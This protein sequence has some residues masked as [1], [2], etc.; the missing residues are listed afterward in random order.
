[1]LKFVAE[2]VAHYEWDAH[3]L[4]KMHGSNLA[5]WTASMTDVLNKGDELAIY[6]MCDMLKRHAFVYTRTKPWTTVDSNVGKLDVTELCMLCDVCLIYLGNKRFGELKCKPEIL[7]PRPRLLPVKLES[8]K[9]QKNSEQTALSPTKELVVGVLDASQSSCTLMTLPCSPTTSILESSKNLLAMKPDVE[10]NVETCELPVVETLCV[11]TSGLET[12]PS[13][14]TDNP[15]SLSM[16]T[17]NP[18]LSVTKTNNNEILEKTQLKRNNMCQ[19][20][21]HAEQQ[22]E[23]TRETTQD[24]AQSAETN[25]T[26][27]PTLLL[28]IQTET[29]TNNDDI[30]SKETTEQIALPA[31]KENSPSLI[32]TPAHEPTDH[33][34]ATTESTKKIDGQPIIKICAC[35]VRLEIL[36]ESDI[37][38]RVHIHHKTDASRTSVETVETKTDKHEGTQNT[39]NTITKSSHQPRSVNKVVD[40]SDMVSDDNKSLSPPRKKQCHN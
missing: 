34:T 32:I 1:M 7:S 4:L 35:T 38:K 26:N 25:N 6:A 8:P 30:V 15:P 28:T 40:Y 11:E 10:T 39:R 24:A 9:T 22:M 5:Q 17:F 3:V 21:T 16:D 29:E 2:N 33:S 31:A 14:T 20:E 18:D 12:Q 37:V 13:L 23:D 36:T 27:L 19:N